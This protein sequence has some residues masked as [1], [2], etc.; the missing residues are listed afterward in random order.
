MENARLVCPCP[1]VEV[2]GILAQQRG[3]DGATDHDVGKAVG[4][5]CAKALAVTLRTLDVAGSASRLV[6]AGQGAY[7][8]NGEGVGGGFQGEVELQ[9]GGKRRGVGVIDDVEI[10]DDAKDALRLL[11]LDLLEGDFLRR[12]NHAYR[13]VQLR[14]LELGAGKDQVLAR[15]EDNVGRGPVGKVRGRDDDAI[16]SRIEL[17][18][19]KES[20]VVRQELLGIFKA[21]ALQDDRGAGKNVAVHIG[22]GAG[23]MSGLRLRCI[24]VLC[25]QRRGYR[26]GCQYQEPDF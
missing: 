4:G 2:A 5:G 3:Q 8:E 1:L 20:V 21:R 14:E 7:P 10:G 17:V 6:D 15:I 18:E 12:I 22:H 13:G 24:R 25:R 19:L 11:Y 23:D 9:L 16:S 26:N